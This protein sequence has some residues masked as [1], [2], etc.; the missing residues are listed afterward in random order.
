MKL[1]VVI[2]SKGRP[3]ILPPLL[4]MLV[5]Q[6]VLPE[7]IFVVGTAESDVATARDHASA[8]VHA[9]ICERAG[10]CA[11]RNRGIELVQ[12]QHG[13][14]AAPYAVVF[15]DDD[16]RPRNDWLEACRRA[17]TTE[18][19]IVGVTGWVLADGVRGEGLTE[20]EAAAYLEGQRAP[21]KHFAS[22]K[23][24]R[25]AEC[26]YGCNMAFRDVVT[27][28]FRFDD[29][30][31]LYG[32]Q[33]DR[34]YSVRASALGRI[35]YIPGCAGVHLGV[36]SGRISGRRFGYSQIANAWYLSRKGTMPVRTSLLFVSRHLV[37]NVVRSF[38][39]NHQIDYPGRLRGN[40]TALL[41]MVRG[42]SHPMRAAEL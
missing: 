41:D 11:Q 22:G 21:E 17:M 24:A 23:D 26:L 9:S 14:D 19:D 34:D 3:S 35:M 5:A 40:A 33:E 28:R 12:Q 38:V 39:P 16:F 18:P 36:K 31:P 7:A 29:N 30:L 1:Y 10:L 4:T 37:S 8:L 42:R 15:L 2:A 27:S 32:W 25:E 13:A 20:S 6:T